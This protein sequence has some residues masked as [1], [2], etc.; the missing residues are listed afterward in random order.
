M[1]CKATWH[2][3]GYYPFCLGIIFGY[4]FLYPSSPAIQIVPRFAFLIL[5]S[6]AALSPLFRILPAGVP[7]VSMSLLAI[8][9]IHNRTKTILLDFLCHCAA[10]TVFAITTVLLYH[11]QSQRDPTIWN[12]PY[13]SLAVASLSVCAYWTLCDTPSIL[14]RLLV[15]FPLQFGGMLV[16]FNAPAPVNPI[17]MAVILIVL[18][19]IT[20]MLSVRFVA[21]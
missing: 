8:S 5:P 21:F 19:S 12:L 16:L 6:A 14:R 10:V 7:N 17:S 1:E 15:A 20:C 18:L 11:A 4:A 13:V 3:Y 2:M 9:P